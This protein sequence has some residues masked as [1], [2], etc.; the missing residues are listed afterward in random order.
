MKLKVNQAIIIPP[1]L[2]RPGRGKKG[3]RI[4]L[5]LLDFMFSG[6]QMDGGLTGKFNNH[7]NRRIDPHAAGFNTDRDQTLRR[8]HFALCPGQVAQNRRVQPG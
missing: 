2:L 8:G 3:R 7:R 4:G 5:G 6:W 1:R